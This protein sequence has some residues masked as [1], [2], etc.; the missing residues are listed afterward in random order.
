ML[1]SFKLTTTNFEITIVLAV[2]GVNA[3]EF[4]ESAPEWFRGVADMSPL[5][6]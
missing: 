3:V 4:I 2:R 1:G 6:A 5:E